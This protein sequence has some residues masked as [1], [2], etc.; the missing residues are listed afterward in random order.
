PIE[1]PT[2][3]P[4]QPPEPGDPLEVPVESRPTVKKGSKGSDVGDLQ[5]LLNGTDLAPGLV[6]DGDFGS[7]TDS[8]VR[9][10]QTS[11]GLMIDGVAGQQP[12]S[13]LY[14]DTPAKP[15]PQIPP[16]FTA[17]EQQHISNLALNSRIA[18]YSWRDRG[19]APNG[20]LQGM[21]LAFGQTYR[22]LLSQHP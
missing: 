16:A 18:N 14:N 12:W 8:A 3:P 19:R 20:Y 1:P 5:Y 13:A 17:E 22:K 7:L 6:V 9:N 4:V 11:R 10:Y 15:Q 21:A 2:E